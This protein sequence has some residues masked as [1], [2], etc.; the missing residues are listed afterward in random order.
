MRQGQVPIIALNHMRSTRRRT[1]LGSL[2]CRMR[3]S[4]RAH[5]P[6]KAAE[7]ELTLTAPLRRLPINWPAL[8]TLS[9]KQGTLMCAHMY[10]A[11]AAT[12]RVNPDMVVH[13]V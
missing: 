4:E 1:R 12:T 2:G 7:G 10:L 6:A 3:D 11:S 13:S 9:T 8:K 5:H